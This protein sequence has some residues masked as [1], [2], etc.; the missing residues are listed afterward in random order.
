MFAL[1]SVCSA[2]G[3][4]QSAADSDAVQNGPIDDSR[5]PVQ[6]ASDSSVTH[7]ITIFREGA[8]GFA[9][10]SLELEQAIHAIDKDHPESIAAAKEALK[11]AAYSISG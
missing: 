2:W 1:L 8:A 9:A 4:K 7:T 11:K 5:V 3:F 10:A 6:P